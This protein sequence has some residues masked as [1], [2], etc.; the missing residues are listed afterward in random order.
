MVGVTIFGTN[1][2]VTNF[3]DQK[4]FFASKVNCE[5]FYDKFSKEILEGYLNTYLMFVA[6]KQI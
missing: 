6:T 4:Y 1:S 5:T 2:L 3:S